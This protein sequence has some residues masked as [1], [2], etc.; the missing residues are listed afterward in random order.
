MVQQYRLFQKSLVLIFL[1]FIGVIIFALYI[2]NTK[3]SG[4]TGLSMSNIQEMRLESDKN[5]FNGE[6]R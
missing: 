5:K 1:T 4:V 2:A 6:P 3:K